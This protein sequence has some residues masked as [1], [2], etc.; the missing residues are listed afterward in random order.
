MWHS[1]TFWRL[2]AAYGLLWLT[3]IGLLGVVILARV[4]EQ[5]LGQIEERL[6]SKA[7]L[8]REVVRGQTTADAPVLQRRI[9]ELRQEI[10]TRITLMDRNGTVLADSDKDPRRH[11]VENHLERPEVQ[12]ALHDR[13]GITRQRGGLFPPAAGF[14]NVH[15]SI[16]IDIAVAQAVRKALPVAFRR[17]LMECPRFGGI[18]PIRLHISKIPAGIADDLRFAIPG[19][20]APGGRF[21]IDHIEN[22]MAKPVFGAV[23]ALLAFGIL[24]P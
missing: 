5:F 12:R 14:Q 7:L 22:L 18:A 21:V 11:E 2:F 4:E 10:V 1:R 17:N 24:V 20:V 8:V 13:F 19:H 6:R 16:A 23:G 9:E 15:P 3:A